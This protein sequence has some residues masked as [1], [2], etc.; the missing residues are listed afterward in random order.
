MN[1]TDMLTTAV[2]GGI[3]YWATSIRARTHSATVVD[4]DT[5]TSHTVTAA[6]MT[7]AAKDVLALYPQTQAAQAIREDNIDAEAA[8]VIFQTAALGG[9]IYG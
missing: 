5:G 1:G 2:E 8:D 9:I 7:A 4:M 3:N 6:G